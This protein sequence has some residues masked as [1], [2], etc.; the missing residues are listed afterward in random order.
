MTI[1]RR[2]CISIRAALLRVGRCRV[3]KDRRMQNCDRSI[4]VCCCDGGFIGTVAS[5]PNPAGKLPFLL[6]R[7]GRYRPQTDSPLSIR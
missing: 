5:L 4:I 6:A 1:I 3:S 7:P 2:I